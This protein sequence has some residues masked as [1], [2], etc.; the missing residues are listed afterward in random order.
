MC[1]SIAQGGARCSAHTAEASQR[2]VSAYVAAYGA[3]APQL[4]PLTAASQKPVTSF[5]NPGD[6]P[7]FSRSK[8]GR[9]RDPQLP[10]RGVGEE[11]D[12]YYTTGTNSLNFAAQLNKATG[13]PIVVVSDD[14]DGGVAGWAMAGV[15]TPQ[16]TVIDVRGE[17]DANEWD[18]HWSQ[19]VDSYGYDHNRKNGLDSTNGY[20]GDDTGIYELEAFG[21]KISGVPEGAVTVHSEAF[22]VL[23]S[24]GHANLAPVRTEFPH[25]LEQ[26]ANDPA[27]TLSPSDRSLIAGM[28]FGTRYGVKPEDITT[29][30]VT[31]HPDGV[32]TGSRVADF[33][34]E[35][36]SG[37]SKAIEGLD[38]AGAEVYQNASTIAN[39][40]MTTMHAAGKGPN[41]R[42]LT[43]D[44]WGQLRS[45]HM[46]TAMM[47]TFNMLPGQ[48]AAESGE[49]AARMLLG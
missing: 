26:W 39:A 22:Q 16:G 20:C 3:D 14:P 27:S 15:R 44:Q 43:P 13:Y 42:D 48:T 30:G 18:E 25:E 7:T 19:L 24:T 23:E 32:A 36:S 41:P 31:V 47:H 45:Q 46:P 37:R 10:L 34:E 8:A 40:Y 38:K 5:A 21:G 12:R 11:A 4:D 33:A 49:R 1:E 35:G 9:T 28:Y 6:V 29:K 17:H 2:A